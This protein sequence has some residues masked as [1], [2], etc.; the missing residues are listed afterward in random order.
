MVS[1]WK[2]IYANMQAYQS[3]P[4]KCHKNTKITGVIFFFG[5]P[6]PFETDNF[7]KWTVAYKIRLKTKVK[8]MKCSRLEWVSE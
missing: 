3:N 4:L 7:K 2:C 1:L 5:T 6:F 8:C